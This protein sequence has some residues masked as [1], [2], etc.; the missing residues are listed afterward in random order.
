MLQQAMISKANFDM[1][2]MLISMMS[3]ILTICFVQ[4]Q[5]SPETDPFF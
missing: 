3:I 2:K 4:D 1:E 5:R